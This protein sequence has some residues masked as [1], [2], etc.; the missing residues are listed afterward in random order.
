MRYENP[1]DNKKLYFPF[2]SSGLRY[3]IQSFVDNVTMKTDERPI[4]NQ[5]TL[6][7]IQ[8]VEKYLH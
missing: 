3:E 4:S 1:Y 2:E 7:I 6:K 8:L 5:E